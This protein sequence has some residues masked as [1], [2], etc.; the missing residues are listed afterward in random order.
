M[1]KLNTFIQN[2][3]RPLRFLSNRYLLATLGFI[4]WMLFLDNNSMLL[5]WELSGEIKQLER[6]KAFFNAEIQE[7]QRAIDELLGS[8]EK[9]ERYAREQHQMLRPGE[10]LYLIDVGE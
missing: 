4:G 5:Q 7:N 10:A 9:F 2:L 3:P 8:P 1:K 6:D